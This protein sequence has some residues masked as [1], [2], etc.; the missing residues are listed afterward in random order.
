[1]SEVNKK[2][3]EEEALS[4]D[5]ASS[6]G[7]STQ[8]VTDADETFRYEIELTDQELSTAWVR[9]HYARQGSLRFWMAPAL[10]L[11]GVIVLAQAPNSTPRLAAFLMLAWGAFSLLKPFLMASQIVRQRRKRGGT[12]KVIVHL[13]ET[14]LSIAKEEP[15]LTGSGKVLV[16]PWKDITAA[17]MRQDYVWYEIRGA[18]RAPIPKRVITNLDALQRYLAQHTRWTKK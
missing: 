4:T 18:Q 11:F 5:G 14:G 17:G 16:F 6:S 7:A 12:R 9:E 1:M 15:A 2:V 10:M 13:D 3:R 8:S